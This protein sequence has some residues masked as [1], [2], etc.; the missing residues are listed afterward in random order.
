[1]FLKKMCGEEVQ[2]R[3]I[4]G[5]VCSTSRVYN[6]WIDVSL[7]RLRREYRQRFGHP[8][9]Y[10]IGYNVQFLLPFDSKRTDTSLYYVILLHYGNLHFQ[11]LK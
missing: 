10:G 7:G 1:M 4:L 9:N 2:I 11:D 3:R 5:F 8:L 6:Y